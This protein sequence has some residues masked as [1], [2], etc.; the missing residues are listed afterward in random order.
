MSTPQKPMA[1]MAAEFGLKPAEYD[2]VLKRL[3]REPNLVELGVFSV[4]WSE[5]CSYK[6]SKNQLKKFPIEGPRVICGPGENAG[7]IG[8]LR[9][10]LNHGRLAGTGKLV[11]LPVDQGFEHGPARSFA[12]NPAGYDP[13]YHFQLA[14]DAG[15]AM[16]AEQSLLADPMG[17][18][19][20]RM[21]EFG[22]SLKA[23]AAAI[24]SSSINSPALTK[25]YERITRELNAVNARLEKARQGGYVDKQAEIEL[26]RIDQLEQGLN[27]QLAA[28]AQS[29]A[30]TSKNIAQALYGHLTGVG[31][32]P[33]VAMGAIVDSV[34]DGTGKLPGR[35][36]PMD[37]AVMNRA[38]AEYAALKRNPAN[39][40]ASAEQLKQ[41]LKERM[42]DVIP[43]VTENTVVPSIFVTSPRIGCGLRPWPSQSNAS[44][45]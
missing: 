22:T 17:R 43:A 16:L 28:Y 30:G 3:G 34:I 5:H 11:I 18:V 10:M 37:V 21:R 13:D 19:S 38:R 8:N 23:N 31:V 42:L 35:A 6:S 20:I 44:T 27:E 29:Q 15:D 36:S 4:M 12:P 7:V 33:D 26:A 45:R 40:N 14:I 25:Q 2:V 1:E 41:A 24:S 9:R 39:K 32:S